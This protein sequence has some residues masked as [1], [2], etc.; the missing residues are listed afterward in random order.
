M[1][2][3]IFT[4]LG[5]L[6]VDPTVRA[7]VQMLRMVSFNSGSQLLHNELKRNLSKVLPLICPNNGIDSC[8]AHRAFR[9]HRK[10]E[11]Q[12]VNALTLHLLH[13]FT[14]IGC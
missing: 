10:R 11:Y 7:S 2:Q 13:S 12:R 1:V 4:A 14:E 3:S 5:D 6:R 9:L 8:G